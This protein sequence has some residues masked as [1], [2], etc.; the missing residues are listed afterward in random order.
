ML[1]T[2]VGTS[3]QAWGCRSERQRVP[4]THRHIRSLLRK[5]TTRV[6]FGRLKWEFSVPTPFFGHRNAILQPAVASRAPLVNIRRM[7]GEGAGGGRRSEERERKGGGS[8]EGWEK[9]EGEDRREGEE[10]GS[11]ETDKGGEGN[12]DCWP[13]C[14]Y[15]FPSPVLHVLHVLSHL[16]IRTMR[17]G[18]GRV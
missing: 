2:N 6:R 5:P 1:A 8:G 11:E 14:V 4:K 13:Q 17:F 16:V 18:R 12:N 15:W 3:E 9:R 7:R 10:G